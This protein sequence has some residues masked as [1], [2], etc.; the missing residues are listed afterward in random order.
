MGCGTLVCLLAYLI[1]GDTIWTDLNVV[2]RVPVT[3]YGWKD[4]E[5]VS[6]TDSGERDAAASDNGGVETM[7]VW[8]DNVTR[9]RANSKLIPVGKIDKS[10]T[11]DHQITTSDVATDFSTTYNMYRVCCQCMMS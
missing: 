10:Q 6:H 7:S 2:P 11:A 1:D 9:Y 8:P 5:D 4:D 3:W